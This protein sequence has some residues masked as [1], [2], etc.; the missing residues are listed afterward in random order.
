MSGWNKK[1]PGG[2]SERSRRLSRSRLYLSSCLRWARN[3]P[4]LQVFGPVLPVAALGPAAQ[5]LARDRAELLHERDGRHRELLAL[6]ELRP[7][8]RAVRLARAR[9]RA[10]FRSAA[11]R[12]DQ[13]PV[14]R[15]V[16]LRSRFSAANEGGTRPACFPAVTS[17]RAPGAAE[18]PVGQADDQVTPRPGGGP[19]ARRRGGTP[20]RGRLLP[21]GGAERAVRLP[22]A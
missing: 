2:V 18:E 19:A 3:S 13:T 20:P 16:V 6:G 14:E 21:R 12:P 11:F 1:A 5:L 9:A 22:G 17:R 15:P 7:L 4:D 10:G 8:G